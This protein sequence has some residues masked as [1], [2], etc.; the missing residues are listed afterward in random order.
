[1]PTGVPSTVCQNPLLARLP[2]F[3]THDPKAGVLGLGYLWRE[4]HA[5]QEILEA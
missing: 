4:V 2:R 5:A 1:M 3:I